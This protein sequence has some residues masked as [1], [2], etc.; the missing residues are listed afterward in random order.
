MLHPERINFLPITYEEFFSAG[1][2]HCQSDEYGK[3]LNYLEYRYLPT[4]DEETVDAVLNSEVDINADFMTFK[5]QIVDKYGSQFYEQA[6]LFFERAT[7]LAERGLTHSALADGKFALEL[8]HY[9]RDGTGITDIIGFLA[10]LHCDLGHISKAGG[11]YELGIKLL[12]PKSR[13]YE[14]DHEMYK[15]LKEMIDGE[16][17]KESL[18]DPDEWD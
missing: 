16:G 3:G 7:K 15:R 9:S 14:D 4:I 2:K 13:F 1:S 6:D 18:E 5:N 17:W 11:Y 12:D 8:S 10:Q